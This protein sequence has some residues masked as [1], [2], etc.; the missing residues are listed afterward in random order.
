MFH[1]PKKVDRHTRFRTPQEVEEQKLAAMKKE[2]EDYQSHLNSRAVELD[3]FHTFAAIGKR[4]SISHACKTV[5]FTDIS[6]ARTGKLME[7][8]THSLLVRA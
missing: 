2:A 4:G 6:T 1:P 5:N 8:G 3:P 7:T